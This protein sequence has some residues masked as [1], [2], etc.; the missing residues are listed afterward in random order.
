MGTR[1]SSRLAFA[2]ALAAAVALPQVAPCKPAGKDI[3]SAKDGW[4]YDFDAAWEMSLKSG[5]PIF[6]VISGGRSPMFEQT[7]AKEL[8]TKYVLFILDVMRPQPQSKKNNKTNNGRVI[9]MLDTD[10]GYN[11]YHIIVP[12]EG[13]KPKRLITEMRRYSK[14]KGEPQWIWRVW[15]RFGKRVKLLL[16]YKG[17]KECISFLVR[18]ADALEYIRGAEA[19]IER[20]E[21]GNSDEAARIMRDALVRI[22]EQALGACFIDDAEKVVAHDRAYLKDFPYLEFVN[23]LR[24]EFEAMEV[25]IIELALRLYGKG[26]HDY[27][28]LMRMYK[29]AF[30]TGKYGPKFADLLARL[31]E[32]RKRVAELPQAD[33]A[34]TADYELNGTEK[35][36][37][38]RP[39]TMESLK[40]LE[41][42]IREFRA[43][44]T[45]K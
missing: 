10:W 37:S 36:V 44:C 14:A 8:G 39:Q 17:R 33:S 4:T 7:S 11:Q 3:P 1:I 43:R 13:Q 23:P 28:K 40:R 45:E 21:D 42:D 5:K 41:M 25:E 29:K 18:I 12:G 15:T 26:D 30:A 22:D 9:S 38:G 31:N 20:L 16:R 32:T 35:R 6:V 2:I 27:D 19:E 34:T 24:N